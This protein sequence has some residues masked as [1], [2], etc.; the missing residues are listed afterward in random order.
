[1]KKY[2]NQ[3]EK[4]R[5]L[6]NSRTITRM[7]VER[8]TTKRRMRKNLCLTEVS[9]TR[10]SN[11][12]VNESWY[13]R[14]LLSIMTW[15]DGV[16]AQFEIVDLYYQIENCP[17]IEILGIDA[18]ESM[19]IFLLDQFLEDADIFVFCNFDREHP[20]FVVTENS[21]LCLTRVYFLSKIIQRG[22]RTGGLP[23]I[24]AASVDQMPLPSSPP[25]SPCASPSSVFSSAASSLD[26]WQ[27]TS[28]NN[29]TCA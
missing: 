10:K 7:T 17:E 26:R 3:T 18:I 14:H 19:W 23:S 11:F 13:V 12:N 29:P 5:P 22:T 1:M 6:K 2:L 25:P 8:R 27:Y 21:I 24:F 9:K 28:T 20:L 15:S 4:H 16:V